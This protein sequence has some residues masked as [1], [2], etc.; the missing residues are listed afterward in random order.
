MSLPP[1]PSSG[2]EPQS[3]QPTPAPDKSSLDAAT[4][5]EIQ[6]RFNELRHEL[7][8]HRVKLADRWLTA[9]AV[10]LTLIGVVAVIAGYIGFQ[11]FEDIET[12][13]EGH[14]E[15]AGRIVEQ[16]KGMHGT[17]QALV[18]S[19]NAETADKDPDKASEVVETVQQSPV[20]SPIDRAVAA[21][22]SLQQ[23][24]EIEQAIEKWRSI[25]NVAEGVDSQLQARA[26]FSVGYLQDEEDNWKEAINA[27][28]KAIKLK[29]DYANAY[30]NRGSA[31]DELGQPEAALADYNEAI[32]LD[33]DMANAYNNRGITKD[34]LGQ[35]E[36]ALADYNEAIRLK[37]ALAE[38]YSNRGN[39]KSGLGQ[40]EAA[41]ADYDEAIRLKPALAEAYNNRGNVKSG[42][43]QPEAALADY[44]EA[45]RLKPD[46]TDAYNGRGNVK[47][48]LGQS[49][50]ALADY[51]EAIRLE[52]AL[53][54]AYNNRGNTK[55]RLGRPNEA[56][57]DY[58]KALA[59]AQES[60]DEDLIAL[61]QSNLS[62]LD[63]AQAP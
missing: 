28:D 55:R 24:G 5:V 2:S 18:A 30:N 40:P 14:A 48:G 53:A 12:K 47:S 59:L 34:T 15:E 22:I 16:I 6:R 17:A 46:Y 43:G 41:L 27:Y 20:A 61:V 21:A 35:P 19:I 11:R 29:P 45:I 58:Q 56:R 23:Q 8:D 25:A 26:W 33:P 60:G 36:A 7:L 51:N 9:T 10:F 39:V 52:P 13:A 54:E 1:S 62:R 31:K 63:N 3:A 38:A 4:D 50:A 42:L 44:D 37:P 32:R 57:E 49:E